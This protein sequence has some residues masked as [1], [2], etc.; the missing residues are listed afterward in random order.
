VI[1]APR[2]RSASTARVWTG[3]HAWGDRSFDPAWNP[4]AEQATVRQL[5]LFGF[6]PPGYPYWTPATLRQLAIRYPGRPVACSAWNLVAGRA[7]WPATTGAARVSGCGF[8]WL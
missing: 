2:V 7:A 4:F 3:R 5:Q 6:P 1:H 8:R